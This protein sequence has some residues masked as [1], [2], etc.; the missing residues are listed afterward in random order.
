RCWAMYAASGEPAARARAAPAICACDSSAGSAEVVPATNTNDATTASTP[1][2]LLLPRMA[3]TLGAPAA[4]PGQR[5][6][7]RRGVPSGRGGGNTEGGD[8]VD[9]RSEE[10][11]SEL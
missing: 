2:T 1:A 8:G 6:G 9:Y 4:Q 5:I 7:H 11:T 3:A 10:H